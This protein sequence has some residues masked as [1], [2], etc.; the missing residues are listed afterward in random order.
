MLLPSALVERIALRVTLAAPI[1]IVL[2]CLSVQA[3]FIAMEIRELTLLAMA[4]CAVWCIFVPLYFCGR[5][6][7]NFELAYRDE[8]AR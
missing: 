8:D 2:L 1:F 5:R 7:G 4:G 3:G 6:W